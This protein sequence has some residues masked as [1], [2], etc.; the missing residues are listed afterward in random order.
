[1][2]GKEPFL[3]FLNYILNVFASIPFLAEL[4]LFMILSVPWIMLQENSNKPVNREPSQG[5]VRLLAGVVLLVGLVKVS[6]S[7]GL[8]KGFPVWMMITY[9]VEAGILFGMSLITIRLQVF[10]SLCVGAAIFFGAQFLFTGVR[11]TATHQAHWEIK[12]PDTVGKM[13]DAPDRIDF[14]YDE[15]PNFVDY[16]YSD[17]ISTFLMIEKK[18]QAELE[19]RLMYQ[20]GL[21]VGHS[22]EKVNGMTWESSR[23]D[24]VGVG[25]SSK[26]ASPFP[27]YYLGLGD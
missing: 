2:M 23:K 22:I 26:G 20:W 21:L 16:I 3:D 14:T 4:V 6:L 18:P 1:M 25:G 5:L 11:L 10:V 19:V 17:Q 9:L 13:T 15:A 27:K 12:R 7:A 8:G 24:G